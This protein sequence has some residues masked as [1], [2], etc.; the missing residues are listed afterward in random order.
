[1]KSLL[2][3][4]YN[5]LKVIW[6]KLSIFFRLPFFLFRGNKISRHSV[7]EKSVYLKNST[8]GAYTYIGMRD[9]LNN[10]QTGNY[11]SIAGGVGIG[12]LEHP[13]HNY[14]TSTFLNPKDDFFTKKTIIGNDVWIGTGCYIRQGVTIGNGAVVGACSFVNKDVPPYAI[15]FGCPAKIYKFRFDEETI[16]KLTESK[17]WEQDPENAKKI[18][19]ELKNIENGI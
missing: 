2:K 9:Y 5:I 19:D 7:I 18:L 12:A 11:C 13:W 6:K 15:V 3:I 4:L 8:I 10:V 16:A 1:M 17:Y 14:S